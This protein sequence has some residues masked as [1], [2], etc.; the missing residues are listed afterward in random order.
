M[1]APLTRFQSAHQRWVRWQHTVRFARS[2]D[3]SIPIDQ[4]NRRILWNPFPL[5]HPCAS[6]LRKKTH[7]F[8]DHL[9][10][11]LEPSFGSSHHFCVAVVN[12][13]S[14]PPNDLFLVKSRHPTKRRVRPH[15]TINNLTEPFLWSINR[16][17]FTIS[18]THL[19]KMFFLKNETQH[20]INKNMHWV[21][22]SIFESDLEN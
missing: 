1:S 16:T 18:V 17:I 4:K 22:T 7:R 8:Y 21:S 10:F 15:L 5:T 12:F 11:A 20:I 2:E 13:R 14:S 3:L 19:F 6:S 9:R